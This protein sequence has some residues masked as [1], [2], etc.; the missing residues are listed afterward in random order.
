ML[1]M[2]PCK[3][4]R[5]LAYCAWLEACPSL[6]ASIPSRVAYP[7]VKFSTT[8]HRKHGNTS[9]RFTMLGLS[10]ITRGKHPD[11]PLQWP[12][13]GV[14]NPTGTTASWHWEPNDWPSDDG[15]QD[16]DL[17]MSP[18]IALHREVFKIERW[19]KNWRRHPKHPGENIIFTPSSHSL[20]VA[21][22]QEIQGRIWCFVQPLDVHQVRSVADPKFCIASPQSTQVS[23]QGFTEIFWE[24]Q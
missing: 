1:T 23:R 8:K 17:N 5:R 2:N 13:V 14:T 24:L 9:C 12:Q 20:G 21:A 4:N 7:A 11:G 15:N 16:I 3:S 19:K 18:G 6:V 10:G 22:P